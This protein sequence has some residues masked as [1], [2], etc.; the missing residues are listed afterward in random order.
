MTLPD[1]LQA[2]V[3]LLDE[4]VEEHEGDDILVENSDEGESKGEGE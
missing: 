1:E 3:D 4:S 2:S